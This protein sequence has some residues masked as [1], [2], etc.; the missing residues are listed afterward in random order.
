MSSESFRE[1]V[2]FCYK[3]WLDLILCIL[4]G[5]TVPMFRDDYGLWTMTRMCKCL[6]TY[7][8]QMT[9]FRDY[10]Y[11]K[12]NGHQRMASDEESNIDQLVP[13]QWVIVIGGLPEIFY[14]SPYH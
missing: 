5:E 14:G 1:V 6:V 7:S 11:L 10:L 12:Q 4:H 8:Y 9:M 2:G 13:K 3:Y